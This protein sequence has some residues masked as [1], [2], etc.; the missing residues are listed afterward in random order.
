MP[1]KA[2]LFLTFIFILGLALP[3]AAQLLERPAPDNSSDILDFSLP[4]SSA[5]SQRPDTKTENE[6]KPDVLTL[7]LEYYERCDT[8]LYPGASSAARNDFCMCSA[9]VART[10]LSEKELTLLARGEGAADIRYFDPEE[11][12]E[13]LDTQVNLP[14]LHYIIRDTESISCLKSP[15]IQHFFITQ[16]AYEDMCRCLSSKMGD[17]ISAY[18]LDILKAAQLRYKHRKNSTDPAILIRQWPDYKNELGKTTEECLN[19]YGHK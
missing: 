2:F 16:N 8:S 5:P 13:K 15:K 14:C 12:N 17:Y 18:G 10:A 19:R 3:A 11:F 1:H 9:D 6:N 7:A 4:P